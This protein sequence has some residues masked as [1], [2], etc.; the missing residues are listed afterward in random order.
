MIIKKIISVFA[1][2]ALFASSMSFTAFSAGTSW[3]RKSKRN[4]VFDCCNRAGKQ[5]E[6]RAVPDETVLKNRRYDN[7]PFKAGTEVKVS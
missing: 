6:H 5:S 1:A 7:T 4:A 2:G 3:Q